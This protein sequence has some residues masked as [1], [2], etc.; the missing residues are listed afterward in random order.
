[1]MLGYAQAMMER[2]REEAK[3]REFA[4]AELLAAQAAAAAWSDSV[5]ASLEKVMAD[6]PSQ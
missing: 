5:L 3:R 1:M 2:A 6:A 4:A